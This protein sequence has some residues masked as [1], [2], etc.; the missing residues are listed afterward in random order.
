M[1]RVLLAIALYLANSN[2]YKK[3]K[4]FLRGFLSD[5]RSS[6]RKYFDMYV[7]SLAIFSVALLVYEVQHQELVY[8]QDVGFVITIMFMAEYLLRLW[9]CG[10]IHA[11]VIRQM[12][13]ARFFGTSVSYVALAKEVLK[14]KFEYAGSFYGIIDLLAIL[15]IYQPLRIFR[16][17]LIFRLF[18]FFRIHESLQE[19]L[20]AFRI[21]SFELMFLLFMVIFVLVFFGVTFYVLEGGPINPNL[22]SFIDAFYFAAISSFTVGYGDIVPKSDETKI[23]SVLMVVSGII[24]ISM[25]TSVVV[26]AMHEKLE[27]IKISRQMIRASRLEGHAVVC[28]YGRMGQVLTKELSAVKDIVVIDTDYNATKSATSRKI[29]AI[30]ADASKIEVLKNLALERASEVLVLTNN[31]AI[32]LSIILGVR[33]LNKDIR[34]ISRCNTIQSEKKLSVAGSNE[35]IYPY[36]ISAMMSYGYEK[37]PFVFDAFYGFFGESSDGAFESF[38]ITEKS[39]LAG[40]KIDGFNFDR[41]KIVLFGLFSTRDLDGFKKI[42][43]ING[44]FYFNPM[45]LSVEAGDELVFFGSRAVLSHET[46]SK[47]MFRDIV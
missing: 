42:R 46:L 4:I 10:D 22:N 26:S 2:T 12:H 38:K 8:L 39:P 37:E 15:P 34:I 43:L 1:D 28:G 47:V 31:D 45:G 5:E 36:H 44:Y 27:D 23:I 40:K 13:D 41:F 20:D 7:V 6:R 21:R 18:K 35:V 25:F 3:T 17:F 11:I 14:K 24:L 33:Q 30:H 16:I 9:A 19:F 32:N 29:N